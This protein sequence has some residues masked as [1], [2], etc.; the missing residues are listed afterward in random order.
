MSQDSDKSGLLGAW[1]TELE[2]RLDVLKKNQ[3]QAKAG[4]RVDG[5]HRPQTRGERGAVSSQ[6]YLA[7]GLQQ[8]MMGLSEALRVLRDMGTGSREQVVMGAW[9]SLEREAGGSTQ[10]VL[11]PGGDCTTLIHQGLEVQ[12]LSPSAPLMRPLLGLRVGDG[13]VLKGRGEVDIL[14][15]R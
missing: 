15:I 1:R 11:L 7:Q 5:S 8:R 12:V 4:T 10:T 6:G 14:W 3:Q 9:F 2:G 13:T